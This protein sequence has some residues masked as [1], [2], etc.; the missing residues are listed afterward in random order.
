M[1]IG[2]KNL[3]VGHAYPFCRATL[4]YKKVAGKEKG[5]FTCFLGFIRRV[6]VHLDGMALENPCI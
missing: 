4:N 1:C 6:F 5:K 3:Y 2:K